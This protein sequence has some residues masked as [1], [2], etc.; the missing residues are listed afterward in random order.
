M[1]L[2]AISR[3]GNNGN[4][5]F[6]T[7]SCSVL[8]HTETTISQN[9]NKQTT[10]VY[11]LNGNLLAHIDCPYFKFKAKKF[12][13]EEVDKESFTVILDNKNRLICEKYDI[14]LYRSW[15]NKKIKIYCSDSLIAKGICKTMFRQWMQGK[16]KID[17]LDV[18]KINIIVYMIIIAFIV[19]A[20]E[21][22]CNTVSESF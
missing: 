5:D 13:V 1:I 7:G 8:Y 18:G 6:F 20:D 21:Y 14:C 15:F 12:F 16:Y 10:L 3:I 17:I 22:T 9:Q 4:C 19:I 2:K 11:D